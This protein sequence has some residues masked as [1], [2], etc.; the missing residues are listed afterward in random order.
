MLGRST[1]PRK[2][3][4]WTLNARFSPRKS[5]T[6]NILLPATENTRLLPHLRSSRVPGRARQKAAIWPVVIIALLLLVAT[7]AAAFAHAG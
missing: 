3:S 4:L 1:K 6:A 2:R 5:R 7:A